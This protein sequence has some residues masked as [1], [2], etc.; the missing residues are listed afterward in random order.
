MHLKLELLKWAVFDAVAEGLEHAEIDA[1]EIA[2]TTA[3]MALAE[4]QE[5]IK[6]EKKTDFE[7]VDEIVNVFAKYKIDFGICHDF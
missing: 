1:D 7:I 5:I 2:D 4:I 3:I 6:D